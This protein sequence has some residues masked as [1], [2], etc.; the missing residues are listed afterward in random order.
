VTRRLATAAVLGWLTVARSGTAASQPPS[1][2]PGPSPAPP[3]GASPSPSP[4]ADSKRKPLQLDID[5]Q[6][7]QVLQRHELPRFET[8]VEVVG[9]PP[10]VMLQRHL[11][12]FDMECGPAGGP[13]TE[14]EMREV[15]NHMAPSADFLA[16]GN[17]LLGKLV[18]SRP[19]DRFFLYRI[20]RPTGV[21]YTLR[22]DR[23]PVSLMYQTTAVFELV[24]SYADLETATRAWRRL[25]RGGDPRVPRDPASPMPPWVTAPCR[26]PK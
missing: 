1:P 24:E 8:S 26:P 15:R 25:E 22:P 5:R 9:T 3:P 21:T 2:S 17:Y 19:P 10:E 13:P 6:V 18:K 12:G 20:L 4:A 11:K 7:D 23:L 14:A 16:L